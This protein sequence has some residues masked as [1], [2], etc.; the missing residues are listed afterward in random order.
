MLRA[1]V[2]A[3]TPRAVAAWR[4][5]GGALEPL[6]MA[7]SGGVG[8]AVAAA[9]GGGSGVVAACCASP[10]PASCGDD[11]TAE[12]LACAMTTSALA[13]L[14][15]VGGEVGTPALAIALLGASSRCGPAV[16]AVAAADADSGSATATPRGGCMDSAWASP[17]SLVASRCSAGVSP[18]MLV[19][20]LCIEACISEPASSNWTAAPRPATDTRSKSPHRASARNLHHGHEEN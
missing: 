6:G 13:T 9:R 3:E 14:A 1:L 11:P 19:T 7:L 10:V 17:K 16:L 4:S 15:A 2:S 12:G 5:F 8:W 18:G 20:S